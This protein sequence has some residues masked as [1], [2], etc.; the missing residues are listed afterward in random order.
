MVEDG[1]ACNDDVGTRVDDLASRTGLYASI[2]LEVD[3]EAGVV[4]HVADLRELR[5]G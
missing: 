1:A 2:Y 3:V 5:R 4:N